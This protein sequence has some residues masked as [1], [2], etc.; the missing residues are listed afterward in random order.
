[1]LSLA[2]LQVGR[3]VFIKVNSFSLF[4]PKDIAASPVGRKWIK[5][6]PIESIC[7][8]VSLLLG[9]VYWRVQSHA[10]LLVNLLVNLSGMFSTLF[11]AKLSILLVFLVADREVC[12]EFL[13][14]NIH[15]AIV[16][17]LR[18]NDFAAAYGYLLSVSRS[19][20]ILL[21]ETSLYL[22]I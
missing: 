1:M 11:T 12:D 8:A 22:F 10:I 3:S 2:L 18:R 20:L 6:C 16:N 15:S 13:K 14:M 5:S 19:K 21:K 9:T 7:G 17:V 4:M